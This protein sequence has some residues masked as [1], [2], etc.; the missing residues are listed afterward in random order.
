M[1]SLLEPNTLS[2]YHPYYSLKTKAPERAVGTEENREQRRTVKIT[3]INP[4]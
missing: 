3:L 2:T 4:F 1:R